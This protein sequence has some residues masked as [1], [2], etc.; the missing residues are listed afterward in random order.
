MMPRY[1]YKGHGDNNGNHA[2]IEKRFFENCKF[3]FQDRLTLEHPELLFGTYM[4]YEAIQAMV[5]AKAITLSKQQ[6]AAQHRDEI[7]S[8]NLLQNRLEA[9]QTNF[10]ILFFMDAFASLG[11]LSNRQIK[12]SKSS[13]KELCEKLFKLMC[14]DIQSIAGSEALSLCK[15]FDQGGGG[16]DCIGAIRKEMS[17]E[18]LSLCAFLNGH[19]DIRSSQFKNGLAELSGKLKEFV[20]VTKIGKK[21]RC[22]LLGKKDHIIYFTISGI[23]DSVEEKIPGYKAAEEQIKSL[24]DE[25]LSSLKDFIGASETS[26]YA[27]TV[28][29][30]IF[31]DYKKT[32]RGDDA[33]PEELRDLASP[34]GEAERK[35]SC[36]ERKLSAYLRKKEPGKELID[37]EFLLCRYAP[38]VECYPETRRIT[39]FYVYGSG[40]CECLLFSTFRGRSS[41]GLSIGIHGI[42]IVE[43]LTGRRPAMRIS[44]QEILKGDERTAREKTCVRLP[45]IKIIFELNEEERE[46]LARSLIFYAKINDLFQKS[47]DYCIK[48]STIIGRDKL[49]LI[50]PLREKT[51][52]DAAI[53]MRCGDDSY[54]CCDLVS[55]CHAADTITYLLNC[56]L[57]GN[58]HVAIFKKLLSQIRRWAM[59]FDPKDSGVVFAEKHILFS[60][61]IRFGLTGVEH[62]DLLTFFYFCSRLRSLCHFAWFDKTYRLRELAIL[63]GST[64]FDRPLSLSVVDFYDDDDMFMEVASIID[65]LNKECGLLDD[66]R[67]EVATELVS[68]IWS[69]H[70]KVEAAKKWDI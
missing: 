68:K 12:Q 54:N 35:F 30:I 1:A 19:E 49:E 60:F 29:G 14:G 2:E 46:Y 33:K 6:D 51:T 45:S 4:Y 64:P 23:H 67:T 65:V 27:E 47:G 61:M 69:I 57:L 36:C 22:L 50:Q 24:I 25:E 7:R 37:F 17:E 44:A 59:V 66:N 28:E 21:K 38:C 52:K 43:I 26:I 34:P 8:L 63:I 20:D 5:V 15:Y 55:V 40:C 48:H 3:S 13:R 31:H 39:N 70:E 42:W 56:K 62:D 16:S 10:L 41:L 11:D 53:F 58:K 18:W 32:L 9:F